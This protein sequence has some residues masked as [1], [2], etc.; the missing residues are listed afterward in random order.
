[1]TEV[2]DRE[3]MDAVAAGNHDAFRDLIDRHKDP[4]VSYLSHLVGDRDRGEEYAQEVFLRL[5]RHA[6]Q[7]RDEGRLQ[8]YLFRIGTN[9]VRTDARRARRWALL[10]PRM[11]SNGHHTV[12]P[13]RD[14]LEQELRARV[15]EA[16]TELP[17]AFRA[18]LVLHEIEGW[19]YDEIARELGCR[20]GTV[21]SRIAR[22][23]E[24]LRRRL[25]AYWNGDRHG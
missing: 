11:G 25:S 16:V 13:Q 9:L 23:R 19:S 1:M 2:S 12:T 21:K 5:Y 22:G 6:R 8:G 3:L 18:P 14:L 20:L 24:R 15:M 7:Y 10:V 17:V 4:L